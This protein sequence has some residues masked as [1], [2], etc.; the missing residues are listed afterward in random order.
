MISFKANMQLQIVPSSSSVTNV[1]TKKQV[2]HPL[3]GLTNQI[4]FMHSQIDSFYLNIKTFGNK[5]FDK[6][7]RLLTSVIVLVHHCFKKM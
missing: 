7:N 4:G 6:H 2:Y 5:R 3:C 1:N